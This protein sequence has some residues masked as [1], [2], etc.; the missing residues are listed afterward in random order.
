[1]N[2]S[3]WQG[4]PW[5]AFKSFAILFSFVVNLV[6]IIVLLVAAPIILPVLSTVVEPLV[7]G[8][9]DNFVAMGEAKIERTIQVNDEIPIEFILPLQQ[10]TD[11]I[12]TQAVPLQAQ[13][14]FTL[15]NGGGEI[16]GVVSLELPAGMTLPIALSLNVPVSQTVPVSLAVDV[17]IPLNETELGQPFA[18]LQGLFA[19]LD[20]LV[21]NLP[22]TNRELFERILY[23]VPDDTTLQSE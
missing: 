20:N 8:L 7:G 4:K 10:Q 9:N 21:T 23:P 5:Q 16:N 2:N 15:P 18:E 1:M 3:F 17:L 13:T 22:A 11:V 19:P 12:I 14:Q 6:L